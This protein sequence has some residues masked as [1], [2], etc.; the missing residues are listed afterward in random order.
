M[1]VDKLEGKIEED[2]FQ[3]RYEKWRAEQQR[4]QE[5]VAR[6]AGA[7][8]DYVEDGVRLIELA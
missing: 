7:N 6:H 2:F 4:I 1:Y 5:Q 3:Q 8:T